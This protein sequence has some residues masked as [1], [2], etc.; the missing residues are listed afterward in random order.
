MK[1]RKT[2]K[3]TKAELDSIAAAHIFIAGIESRADHLHLG[4]PMWHGWALREAFLAGIEWNKMQAACK[5][6][7]T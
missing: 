7:N 1:K 5:G 4:Y 6:E 2:K 3:T